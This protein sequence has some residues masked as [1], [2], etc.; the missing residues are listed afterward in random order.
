MIEGLI[1]TF[2]HEVVVTV[3]VSAFIGG[4]TYPFKKITTAYKE[5]QESLKSIRTE[6][7]EQR[8]NHLSHI[9]ASNEKQV[10]LLTSAVDVLREM[11]TDTKVLLDRLGRN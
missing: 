11:H 10:E 7:T 4:L 2:R 6:L 1:S 3:L 5:T 9:E 8:S